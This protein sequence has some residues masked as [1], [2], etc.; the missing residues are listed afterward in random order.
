M[1]NEVLNIVFEEPAVGYYIF[2]SDPKR[3]DSYD[4]ILNVIDGE[5]RYILTRH[6]H[7]ASSTYSWIDLNDGEMFSYKYNSKEEAIK[8]WRSKGDK[9]EFLAMA[10]GYQLFVFILEWLKGGN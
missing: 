3:L 8:G 2:G 1:E 4:I 9:E 5:P 7:P 10:S 6:G